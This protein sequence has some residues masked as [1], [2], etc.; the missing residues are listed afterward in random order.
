MNNL[1]DYVVDISVDNIRSQALFKFPN[2]YGAS[3]IQGKYT[4]GGDQG[5]YELAVIKW[6]DKEYNMDYTTNITDD[7]LGYLT[8]PEVI[9]ILNQILNLEN[10]LCTTESNNQLTYDA[11]EPLLKNLIQKLP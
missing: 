7:V 11:Q 4:Y 9:D 6:D 10:Q 1:F 2:G 3:L 8:E 5:L